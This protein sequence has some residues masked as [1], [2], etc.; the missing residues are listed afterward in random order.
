[1]ADLPENDVTR[2]EDPE[3]PDVAEDAAARG[4]EGEETESAEAGEEET[5][6]VEAARALGGTEED[7][8]EPSPRADIGV[9]GATGG[10]AITGH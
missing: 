9:T 4:D 1:M 5:R 2:A 8:L 3:N 6:R 10:T 7:A